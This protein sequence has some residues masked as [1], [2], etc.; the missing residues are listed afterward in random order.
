MIATVG[1]GTSEPRSVE[2]KTLVDEMSDV[3]SEREHEDSSKLQRGTAVDRYVV[4]YELGVGGMGVV[5]AAYDPELDRKVALKLLHSGVRSKRARNRL[6][7]EAKAIARLTHPNV[8]TV[9]DVGTWDGRIFVAMEY[10][11]GVTLRQWVLQRKRTWKEIVDVV[12]DA[13]EGLAAAHAADLIHRDFKPDNVIVDHNGRVVVLDFG[14]ARKANTTDEP[15]LGEPRDSPVPDNVDELSLELTRDGAKL[16]TPAYMAPEQHLGAATDRRTDQ[17]SFCVVLWEALFGVR[18]FKGDNHTTTAL[19]VVRGDLQEPPKGINVPTWL[20][21]ALLRGLSTDPSSRYPSMRVL[22]D[23]LTRNP[24]R[25]RRRRIAIAIGSGALALSALAVWGS[26]MLSKQDP[27]PGPSD[28]IASVW[29]EKRGHE[30]QAAF[31]ATGAAYAGTAFTGVRS[32]LD[33]YVQEWASAWVDACEATHVHREQSVEAMDLRMACLRTSRVELSALV[34]EFVDADASVV[35]RAVEAAASLPRIAECGNVDALTTRA[36]PPE[37]GYEREQ[38]EQAR[39]ELIDARAKELA[40]RY[41]Q[42]LSIAEAVAERARQLDYDPLLAE[43]LLRRGST[44]ERKGELEGAESSLLEAVRAAKAAGHDQVEAEAWV[45]LVWVTGVERIDVA[46]G[47]LWAEFADATLERMGGDDV[48]EATLTHNL[49]GVL[50]RE[51]RQDEALES[52]REALK[53][54]RR[55]LGPDDPRVA[56]TLNHIGNVL[57]EQGQFAWAQEYCER[58]LE[59][60]RRVLGR[61][62]PKVAA[63][64]NNLAEVARKQ[65]NAAQALEFADESLEIV[66]GSSWP[67]EEVA[68][69]IAAWANDELGHTE[70]SM[71]T[72]RR[73]VEVLE[74]SQAPTGDALAIALHRLAELHE[75]RGEHAEAAALYERTIAGDRGPRPAMAVRGLLGLAVARMGQGNLAGA[76]DSIDDASALM[77]AEKLTDAGLDAMLEQRRELLR[78]REREDR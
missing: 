7:R 43:A 75:G 48:L 65:G 64:L 1:A 8:V 4:L 77:R 47:H 25:R 15:A 44:L 24:E 76:R 49:G 35:E 61:R 26:G 18:P 51:G 52:Y 16:G 6:M 39:D 41:D 57:M 31:D 58:S 56:M 33:A 34:E 45:E 70:A 59:A 78:E 23:D 37:E 22:L 36:R 38:V 42:A 69:V 5:Y 21:A 71:Q 67:E 72:H 63:S 62:H 12:V 30:V 50:Y 46:R 10:V 27:C 17:F 53:E 20:R 66:G 28:R 55:L 13:G 11:D 74:G 19:H 40:G 3:L 73:L 32:V 14:L 54:Q 9:H 29:D 2:G 60:R 68:L